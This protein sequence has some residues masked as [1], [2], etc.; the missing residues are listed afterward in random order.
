MW[1]RPGCNGR[2]RAPRPSVAERRWSISRAHVC[3]SLLLLKSVPRHYRTKDKH[4][5]R[6]KLDSILEVP[7]EAGSGSPQDEATS[8]VQAILDSVLANVA[9]QAEGSAQ[10]LT[11]SSVPSG[12][13]HKVLTPRAKAAMS[14]PERMQKRGIPEE[15]I[16]KNAVLRTDLPDAYTPRGTAIAAREPAPGAAALG[17]GGV[18]AAPVGQ[19]VARPAATWKSPLTMRLVLVFDRAGGVGSSRLT[20]RL[21]LRKGGADKEGTPGAES[22]GGEGS[23]ETEVRDGQEDGQGQQEE[24]VVNGEFVR[25][26]EDGDV[27]RFEA[28][29]AAGHV[30]E[31]ITS[32]DQLFNATSTQDPRSGEE[33][34]GVGAGAGGLGDKWQG[35]LRGAAEVVAAVESQEG[36]ARKRFLVK[37]EGKVV[38]QH[39]S[40]LEAEEAQ[41][42]AEL[43]RLDVGPPQGRMI[44]GDGLSVGE[45]GGEGGGQGG[46][47]GGLEERERVWQERVA[48]VEGVGALEVA[49]GHPHALRRLVRTLKEDPAAMVGS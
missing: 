41:L 43:Q 20:G 30:F 45:E 10:T 27:A 34:V 35:S 16:S 47:G 36:G 33:A 32:F 42:A 31:G 25:M 28:A 26:L 38:S 40:Q 12:K 18:G 1:A 29:T 11:D 5:Q 24:I 9:E 14:S 49:R 46:R 2:C 7:P 17:D 23:E 6:F 22:T 19:A 37:F 8:A 3:S 21:L 48:A 39:G 15:L 13:G 4:T 44:G